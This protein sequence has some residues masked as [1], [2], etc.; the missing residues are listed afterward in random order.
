MARGMAPKTCGTGRQSACRP[1]SASKAG[2]AKN[3]PERHSPLKKLL[4]RIVL[5]SR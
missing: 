2:A 3:K 5:L 4:T 1:A